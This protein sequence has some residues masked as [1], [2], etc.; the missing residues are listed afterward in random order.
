MNYRSV[1]HLPKTYLA[2]L[3]D[4]FSLSNYIYYQVQLSLEM[5]I[6]CNLAY[7]NNNV[8][9]IVFHKPA[10]SLRS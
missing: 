10:V 1:R 9:I 6:C 7:L 8:Q 4:E 2:D 5:I 3:K